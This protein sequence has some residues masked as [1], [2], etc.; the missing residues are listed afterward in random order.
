M[1]SIRIGFHKYVYESEKLNIHTLPP[2]TKEDAK[3]T[4]FAM[5]DLL[6]EKGVDIY[7]AF[8]TLLGAVREKDFIDGDLDVDC[9]VIDRKALFDCLPYLAEHGMKLVR[10]GSTIFSFRY[11]DLKGCYI[12]LYVRRNTF[13]IWAL[14]CYQLNTSM[15]PRKYLQDGEIDFLGR[16]FKCPKNPKQVL[17][18]WY[19]ETWRTPIAKAQKE[20]RYTVTSHYFYRKIK[21]TIKWN[22]KY[23]IQRAIGW[24]HWRHLVKAE[25]RNEKIAEK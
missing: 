3:A 7:L 16:T 18:F 1:K 9:Y 10:A 6:N 17:A 24:Y 8:G 2:I 19:G 5:Q 4:L 21:N 20:Y 12:D 25:Y 23:G 15:C 22:I 14:Y 11:E 13:N